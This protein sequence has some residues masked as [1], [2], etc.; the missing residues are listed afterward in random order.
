MSAQ[1]SIVVVTVDC[2]R[3]DHV[4][5]MGYE[6]PTTPFLASKEAGKASFPRSRAFPP[7]NK[8]CCS[9]RGSMIRLAVSSRRLIQPLL[10]LVRCA[11]LVG[12]ENP[13]MC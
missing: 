2:L 10:R 11:H 4:G 6:R 12:R 5:F 7:S 13:G 1:K 3:A 9:K 8:P